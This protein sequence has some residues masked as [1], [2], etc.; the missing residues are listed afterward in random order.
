MKRVVSLLCKTEVDVASREMTILIDRTVTATE[1][2]FLEKQGKDRGIKKGTLC[3]ICG[4]HRSSLL[5]QPVIYDQV[6]CAC[7]N[8]QIQG[9]LAPEA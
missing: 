9:Y 6:H 1:N 7:S 4:E 2:G 5:S 3:F 8:D